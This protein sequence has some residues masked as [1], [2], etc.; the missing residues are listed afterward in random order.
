MFSKTLWQ[1]TVA[2]I[3][4]GAASEAAVPRPSDS[5]AVP[6]TA[7]GSAPVLHSGTTVR[8]AQ[9]AAPDWRYRYYS[10]RWWYWLPSNQW[11]VWNGETWM[12]YASQAYV[13]GGSPYAY[14][15]VRTGYY[16]YYNYPRYGGYYSSYYG[17]YPRYW[18]GPARR[19]ARRRG[20]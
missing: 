15:Q 19:A 10:G 2:V 16:G 7:A 12:P 13:G 18:F 5:P 20:W 11:A 14:P 8:T 17:G 3:L 4:I 6:V 9:Y 1:V